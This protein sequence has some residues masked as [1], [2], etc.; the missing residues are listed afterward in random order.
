M[1]GQGWRMERK[2][3]KGLG[4]W[5]RLEKRQS[6]MP[7]S[8]RVHVGIMYK[9]LR[10]IVREGWT[11]ARSRNKRLLAECWPWLIFACRTRRN[12]QYMVQTQCECFD[13][14]ELQQSVTV[15]MTELPTRTQLVH[16]SI[17]PFGHKAAVTIACADIHKPWPLSPH[18]AYPFKILI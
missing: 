9:W 12:Y 18:A 6:G 4:D 13:L 15:T 10:G 5:E 14:N 3:E 11:G 17:S 7:R 8:C 16:A 1:E 2:S